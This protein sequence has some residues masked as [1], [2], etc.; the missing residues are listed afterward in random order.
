MREW[1]TGTGYAGGEHE[2][3]RCRGILRYNTAVELG[4][5]DPRDISRYA[6]EGGSG[7]G[8]SLS[9]AGLVAE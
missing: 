4:T 5:A 8:S 3:T 9:A 1:E 7:S 6:T 2:E